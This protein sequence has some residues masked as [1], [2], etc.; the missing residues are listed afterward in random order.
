MASK[1]PV[2]D[3]KNAL[4][5]RLSCLGYDFEEGYT[6]LL[7]QTLHAQGFFVIDDIDH[8]DWNLYHLKT[9]VWNSLMSK[10]LT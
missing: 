1:D 8:V 3:L 5:L 4:Q 9:L 7:A 10:F 6:A 2:V